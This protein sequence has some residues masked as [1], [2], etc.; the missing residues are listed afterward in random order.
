MMLFS[1]FPYTLRVFKYRFK[2]MEV[3][4]QSVAEESEVSL[5]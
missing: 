3:D 2:K 5:P 4:N 1:V